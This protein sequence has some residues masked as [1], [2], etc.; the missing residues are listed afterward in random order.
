MLLGVSFKHCLCCLVSA[1]GWAQGLRTL[2][3][4]LCFYSLHDGMTPLHEQ[5]CKSC[6]CRYGMGQL[7]L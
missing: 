5:W 4:M 3:N 6:W 2:H 7:L 1:A